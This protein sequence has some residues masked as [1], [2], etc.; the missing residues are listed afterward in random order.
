[1]RFIYFLPKFEITSQQ[2][3]SMVADKRIQMKVNEINCVT[4]LC[5]L[6]AFN[7]HYYLNKNIIALHYF[8]TSQLKLDSKPDIQHYTRKIPFLIN[9]R[10]LSAESNVRYP[11]FI[12]FLG[13]NKLNG[14]FGF[15]LISD[16]DSNLEFEPVHSS[17]PFTYLIFT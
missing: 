8:N 4:K 1:M 6:V 2:S 17:I 11:V 7:H 9:S 12:S 15:N 16:T 13:H 14:N 5:I 3:Q 10:E